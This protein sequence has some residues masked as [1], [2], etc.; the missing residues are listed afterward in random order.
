MHPY[1]SVFFFL[2]IPQQISSV[3][4]PSVCLC[5]GA[6]CENQPELFGP[7]S[8][9]KTSI[10]HVYGSFST[11][12]TLSQKLSIVELCVAPSSPSSSWGASFV[13]KTLCWLRLCLLQ[14]TCVFRYVFFLIPLEW[15]PRS[16]RS[17]TSANIG[18]HQRNATQRWTSNRNV[19]RL[20]RTNSVAFLVVLART[21]SSLNDLLARGGPIERASESWKNSCIINPIIM[22]A[23]AT[24]VC[25]SF[26]RP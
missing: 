12:G 3:W 24:L 14:K 18:T 4:I 5:Q 22:I 16:R 11:T 7:I 15:P 17:V 2:S 1:N 21:S 25:V 9:N 20:S 26:E 19:A 13:S 23:A 10:N 6:N 8:I